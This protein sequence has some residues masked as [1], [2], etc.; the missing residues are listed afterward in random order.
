MR[1]CKSKREKIVKSGKGNRVDLVN[2][3]LILSNMGIR[4]ILLEG[5]GNLNW[6]FVKH[7]LID[8]TKLTIPPWIVGGKEAI[9]LIEGAGFDKIVEASKYKLIKLNNRDNYIVLRYK[10]DENEQNG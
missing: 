7:G 1:E 9:G 4:T 2:L 3:L 6:S 8:E 5:G 10:K